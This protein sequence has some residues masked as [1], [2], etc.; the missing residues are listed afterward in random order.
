VRATDLIS[1]LTVHAFLRGVRAVFDPSVV[2]EYELE[3][4]FLPVKSTSALVI[5]LRFVEILEEI[6][7]PCSEQRQY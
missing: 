3:P 6:H 1:R 7:L 4:A 5:A 2:L